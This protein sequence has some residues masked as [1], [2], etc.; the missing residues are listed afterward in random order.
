M[1]E[2]SDF[3][4]K[5]V[6]IMVSFGPI[7]GFLLTILE[8]VFP[9]LPLGAIVGLNMISF[10][11]FF[12]F[13]ISYVATLTGC[14]MSFCLF[15]YLFR[16]KYLNWF[17]E[18]NRLVIDK[19]MKKLSNI[20]FNTLVVIFALPITP[21]FFVNIAGGLSKISSKKYLIAMMIGKPAMLLF[22]GYIA[23]SF[24]DS[25]KNPINFIK[26]GV[27]V[28]VAYLVSKIVERIVRVEK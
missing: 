5:I 19:W 25:L 24:V 18:K 12:G 23:V 16:D 1:T 8:S 22:Y 28:F 2:I 17:N 6:E 9:P 20:D 3:I 26:V 27:L 4:N 21:A 11:K 14:M 10:G 13:I 15:R 7:G